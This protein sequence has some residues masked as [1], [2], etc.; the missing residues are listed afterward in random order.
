MKNIIPRAVVRVAPKDPWAVTG[1]PI[2]EMF[3]TRMAF[4][5][6]LMMGVGI[7]AAIYGI[8]SLLLIIKS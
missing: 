8:L 6:T 3:P 1:E 4:F 5:K 2:P 7:T